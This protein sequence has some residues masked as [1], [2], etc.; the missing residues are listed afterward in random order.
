VVDVE[1]E[2]REVRVVVKLRV[3]VEDTERLVEDRV[4]LLM[5]LVEDGTKDENELEVTVPLLGSKVGV[6]NGVEEFE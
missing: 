2:V 6:D 3:L 5:S 4:L 1:V